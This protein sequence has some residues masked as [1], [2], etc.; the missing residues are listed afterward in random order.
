MSTLTIKDLQISFPAGCDF[1]ELCKQFPG[2]P[3]KFG[4]KQGECG[5][6]AIKIIAGHHQLTKLT[7]LE[8]QRH[9]GPSIRLAC[10]CGINGDATIEP[11]NL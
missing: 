6:C 10:Q 2:I 5:T 11:Y 1:L 8:K 7:T 3:I 4:C 9:L